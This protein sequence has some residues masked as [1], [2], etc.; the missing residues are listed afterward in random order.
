MSQP[1]H[2][3][4]E[5]TRLAAIAASELLDS[6]AIP[7]LDRVVRTA[8]RVLSVPVSQ[9]NVVTADQQIPVSYVGGDTWGRSVDLDRSYCQYAII[10]GRPLVVTDARVD[11]LVADSLATGESGIVAYLS[12]PIFS[13]RAS[14]PLA[15]LCVVDFQPRAW[16]DEE[17]ATL[18]DLAAWALSEI[19][20]RAGHLRDRLRAEAALRTSEAHLRAI[21][22]GTYEYIGLLSPDGILL[23]C[24]RA[25]LEF[26]GKPRE[27]EVGR[28]FW[29]TSWFAYTPGAADRLRLAIARAATGQFI[30]YEATLK[31]PNGAS[32]SFDF[33]LHPIRDDTGE[34]VFIVP[35]G[36]DIS[37]QIRSR[38]EAERARDRAERLQALTAALARARTLDD[39]ADVVVADMVVALGART[40]ALAGR[41]PEG[42][43]MVL[44]RTVG[45]SPDV[46]STVERQPLDLASP[47][48]ECYRIQAPVWIER[49][50]G[51]DGL[52]RRYPP[53][54][55]VWDH[56][57]V[58]AAAFVP[59]VAAGETIGVISFGFAEPRRFSPEERSFLRSLGQQ[60]ALAVERARLFDAEREARAEAE[61]ANRA[62]SE[63]LAV[64]SHELRTPLNAIGGYTELLE[65]ELRGPLTPQQRHDLERIRQSQVHLLGLINEVL[66]YARLETGSVHYDH[67]DVAV[68]DVFASA[69]ALVE[70]QAQAKEIQLTIH[71]PP[72]GLSAFAD[73]EKVRQILVNLLSNAVKFTDRGGH[74]QLSSRESDGF[75]DI[76]VRDDGMG[77]P[78]DQLERI[79]QPFVQVRSGLTR[80]AEGA[81]LGLAISR[82]LARGMGGDLKATSEPGVGSE[83][84]LR[85]PRREAGS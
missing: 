46:T 57:E 79:F 11:P 61:R 24:N 84:V 34:V 48:T 72:A 15:T 6:G 17:I 23:D 20:L 71:P 29:K 42:D 12:I 2:S 16:T 44:L 52:D 58:N 47:L 70:P 49:R 83:F 78:A 53:I 73:G 76:L 60:A 67:A 13:P 25:S 28:P 22:D 26:A 51:E 64:M 43:A 40:G 31:R 55:P 38:R 50:D 85:L 33:S 19:E 63:F 36:R 37:G 82:D 75:V 45:F 74:V 10:S 27:E 62:K 30:R 39:V 21:Y 69:G 66:S 81:G 14:A 80:T 68:H 77:I 65:M 3:L 8:A 4:D 59:L 5:P 9:L 18:G 1:I 35:E 56:L 7:A 41:A 32:V 54:A